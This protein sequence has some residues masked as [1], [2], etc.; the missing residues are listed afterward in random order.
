MNTADPLKAKPYH[1]N[2]VISV[3]GSTDPNAEII[4]DFWIFINDECA[5]PTILSNLPADQLYQISEPMIYFE[6]EEW[7]YDT[8][9]H[10]DCLLTFSYEA[11]ISPSAFI[12][13][14]NSLYLGPTSATL[15]NM[16]ELIKING[17]PNVY[18]YQVNSTDKMKAYDSYYLIVKGT[19]DNGI[20]YEA[21]S[22]LQVVPPCELTMV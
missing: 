17:S 19:L 1:L 15:S 5:A 8:P 7:A 2:I 4:L 16:V 14:P 21:Y 13:D 22:R 18:Q 9:S 3:V 6:F 20:F 11:Y 12:T 10:F